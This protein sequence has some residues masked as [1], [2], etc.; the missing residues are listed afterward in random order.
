MRLN[1]K[2]KSAV[3]LTLAMSIFCPQAFAAEAETVQDMTVEIQQ[4]ESTLPLLTFEE[5]LEKAIKH[6]PDLRDID[7]SLDL[8]IESKDTLEDAVNTSLKVNYDTKEWVSTTWHTLVSTAFTLE[9]NQSN[10]KY[11]KELTEMGLEVSLKS[12]FASILGDEAELEYK[13]L[14]AENKKTLFMQGYTKYRLGMLSKFNLNQLQMEYET[15]KN[16]V[17]ILEAQLEQQYYTLNNL[18]GVSSANRYQLVY[19]VEYAPYEL[20][21]NM[22]AYINTKVQKEDLSIKLKELAM[23]SAKFKSNYRTYASTKQTADQDK[24][25][26]DQAKRALT[27]AKRDKELAIRN[28]ALSIQQ[29]D[30]GIASAQEGLKQVQAVYRMTQINYQAGNVTKTAVEQAELA[31][32]QTELAL[33]ELYYNYDMLVYT[34]ENTS[35]LGATVEE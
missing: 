24:L 3:A 6:S 12:Y 7:D 32:M 4:K 9:N 27:T 10:M 21:S 26:Y 11:L 31:V 23:E 22:E 28:A 15:A 29:M 18:M 13:K 19:D 33:Q 5:A 16:D 1:Y 2:W 35:L 8:L 14:A 25:S 17:A 30:Q 20:P 34:F